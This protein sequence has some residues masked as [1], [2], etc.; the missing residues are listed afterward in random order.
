M[1]D[2]SRTRL[3]ILA[4]HPIQ[5]FTP[6]YQR[7]AAL[8]RLD[9]RVLFFRDYGV[10]PRFDKQ[11][12]R[13]VQ[14]DIDL[15]SGYEHAFLTNVS[16]V[17][18]PFNPLH[19]INPG[20]FPR[21]LGWA[22][23]LWVNGYLYPSNWLAA[24]AAMLRGVPILFRSDLTLKSSTRTG[25]S[26]RIRDALLRWWIRHSAALLYIGTD[27]RRAYLH[28]GARE[29]QLFF[30]PYSVDVARI[31]R[32]A[33]ESRHDR[34]ELRRGLGL[35]EEATVVLFVGKLTP[36]KRPEAVID[37]VRPEGPPLHLVFA[38]SGPMESQLRD[39]VTATGASATF[40]GFVNQSE[41]PKVYAAADIFILP[42][43][44]EQWGLVLNEAMAAG[45]PAVV[46]DQ[47]GAAAD[48]IVQG[49]TGFVASV[50]NPAEMREY[51]WQLAVSQPLRERIGAAAQQR[52]RLYSY[53]AATRGV[54]AALE[55]I[56]L[57]QASPAGDL[58]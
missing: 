41:L 45:L 53:D 54:V 47:V 17:S 4:S 43:G 44:H 49:T 6:I 33:A 48:L 7:L 37:L 56:Q 20:V 30:A 2:P 28:Y 10:R 34:G 1:R 39:L 19:A 52:S 5:Y 38:G 9:V 51:V 24:A 15:L 27:N 11:F 55:S 21:V 58:I 31:E 46:S 12:D 13:V 29:D 18:D 23:A 40:L 32:G 16:P 14:W 8:P 35:P 26:S 22:D 42:S 57:Y 3:L 50:A 36:W 25:I